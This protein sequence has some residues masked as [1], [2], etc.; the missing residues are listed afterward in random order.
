M[1]HGGQRERR[2]APRRTREGSRLRLLGQRHGTHIPQL[3]R[4]ILI[5]PRSRVAR[6]TIW[7]ASGSST[8]SRGRHARTRRRVGG[9]QETR[10]TTRTPSICTSASITTLRIFIHH[11]FVR[12]RAG[13]GDSG[14][15]SRVTSRGGQ[16]QNRSKLRFRPCCRSCDLSRPF[17]S[18]RARVHLEGCAPRV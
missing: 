7:F 3:G 1:G 6:T 2:R 18:S 10:N 4:A 8:Q 9:T 5:R 14:P 13:R 17:P 11:I 15:R 12:A 16:N